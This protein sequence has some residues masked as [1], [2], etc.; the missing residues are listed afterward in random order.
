M[1]YVEYRDKIKS[2]DILVWS[3]RGLSSLYDLKGL[4]VK[5]F[6][7]SD[8]IH[9]GVAWNYR[10]RLLVLEAVPPKVRVVPLS[11][12]LPFSVIHM[13]MDF[14]AEMEDRAFSDIGIT[15]Y[16]ILDAVLSLSNIEAMPGVQCVEYVRKILNLN[17]GSNIPSEFIKEI[18]KPLIYLE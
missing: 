8:Y 6:T 1:K 4:L 3:Y 12:F 5:T 16:S 7:S 11:N 15:D 17:S 10:G 18:N 14:T 9:V 13:D 2:G